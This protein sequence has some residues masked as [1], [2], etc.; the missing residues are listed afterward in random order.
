MNFGSNTKAYVKKKIIKFSKSRQ[1][2]NKR[3]DVTACE[4]E[5]K[6][7]KK[8]PSSFSYQER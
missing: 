3:V 8:T 1:E 2:Q 5:K 7:K 6:T 4:R